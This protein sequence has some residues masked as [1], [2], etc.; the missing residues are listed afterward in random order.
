MA[1]FANRE[2]IYVSDR[3][4]EFTISEM[5]TSHIINVLAHHVRQVVTLQKIVEAF[6]HERPQFA[7]GFQPHLR[8]I[9]DM[10]DMLSNELIIREPGSDHRRRD[11]HRNDHDNDRPAPAWSYS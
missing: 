11:T 10:I 1:R 7:G 5:K 2:P 6:K 4:E 9:N 8:E 3:G